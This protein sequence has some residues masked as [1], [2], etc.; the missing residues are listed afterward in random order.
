MT[1]KPT[2]PK[3]NPKMTKR[4]W[5][6]IVCIFVILVWCV[7]SSGCAAYTVTSVGSL[8]ATGKGL[9]DHAASA[10]MRGDCDIIRSIKEQSYYCEMPVT[11]NQNAF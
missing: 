1:L 9:T 3:V 6:P 2:L 4:D 5:I 8:A 10:V 7:L 11:Y